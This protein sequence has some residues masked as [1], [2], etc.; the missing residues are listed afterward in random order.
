M[1]HR[2]VCV[3]LG[4]SLAWSNLAFAV[5][6]TLGD[7]A[8]A[9][10][11][12][13]ADSIASIYQR[14]DELAVPLDRSQFDLEALLESLDFD[15][16]RIVNFVRAQIAF[17]AYQG[18]LRGAQGTLVSR[19]GN[20][21]DQSLLL[22]KLL[23]DAGF[24]ARI[25]RGD[26]PPDD[27]RV[28]LQS[29]SRQV[30]WPSP[31]ASRDALE[32][33]T[34]TVLPL[35][36][37]SA[38]AALQDV[39][40]EMEPQSSVHTE[41][42]ASLHR[43]VG[44]AL[45]GMKADFDS[46]AFE[47]NLLTEIE[48]YFWVEYRTGPASPWQTS[49]PV[50]A[51]AEPEAVEAEEYFTDEIPP[52]LQNRVR[53]EAFVETQ[54]G[55]ETMV[56]PLMT[57]WERPAANASFVPQT[58]MLMPVTDFEEDGQLDLEAGLAKA[59]FFALYLN[60]SLASGANVFTLDGLVGPPDALTGQGDFV[61]EVA[62]KGKRAVDA[63]SGLRSPTDHASG[64]LNRVW[65]E[66]SLVAPGGEVRK[67]SRDVIATTPEGRK[68]IRGRAVDQ[69]HWVDEARHALAESREFVVATGPVNPAYS[70]WKNL[71]YAHKARD[72]IQALRKL[73]QAGRLSADPDVLEGLEPLPDFRFIDFLAM[74]NASTGFTPGGTHYLAAPMIVTF[75]RGITENN[76][77]LHQFEQTDIVFNAR[78]S[79][80]WDGTTVTW[81]PR[82]AAL[83]GI[84]DTFLESVPI[85]WHRKPLARSSA[86]SALADAGD[87]LR[88]I[89]PA[90]TSALADL[91]LTPS[92][93]FI[94]QN[95]LQSGY[96]LIV[97][98]RTMGSE[99]AWWRVDTESGT[100]LG[101][102][103]GAGG[104]GGVALTEFLLF[105]SV[106]VATLLMYW[107]F[108]SCFRSESGLA[109]FCCLVDSWLTGIIV[110]ALAVVIAE[111]AIIGPAGA[112]AAEMGAGTKEVALVSSIISAFALDVPSTFLSFTDLRLKAC[113]TLTG[114]G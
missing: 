55:S 102:T 107:S 42:I 106:T 78:R 51:D 68:L 8:R 5:Q 3:M 59:R 48:D 52:A 17:Q 60:G 44:D 99:P 47:S 20:A 63:L 96:G 105:L 30:N 64:G 81:A 45:S 83:Q 90:D 12:S 56:H 50:F 49:H 18:V 69:A 97:P 6:E 27:A 26:L 41:G 76:G 100:V 87:S 53:I 82:E 109:L 65:F 111:M 104:Y 36:K 43:A 72:T 29:M 95:E 24:E 85:G 112:L 21:I 71:S 84:R 79:L 16:D 11:P 94:A 114:S 67:V 39:L 91:G 57:A 89:A 88:Y 15:A 46:N 33:M 110:A 103:I 14:L 77:E 35:S 19:S 101:M 113:G 4:F 74:A 28:L 108:Y 92:A 9:S 10:R 23:K 7:A 98:T 34:R 62:G 86:F 80:R 58:L 61:A 22:A 25:V 40:D 13:G 75:N 73:E 37:K 38:D 31:F 66:Y 93:R 1:V 70:I 2:C 32:S 54:L